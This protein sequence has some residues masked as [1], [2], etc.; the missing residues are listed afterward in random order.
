[1][2]DA[3]GQTALHLSIMYNECLIVEELL[4]K[5]ISYDARN[6]LG[7]TPLIIGSFYAY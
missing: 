4:K 1:M 5:G 3:E 6:N 7:Y 2:K